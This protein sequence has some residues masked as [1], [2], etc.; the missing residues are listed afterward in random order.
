[1]V[2]NKVK[3]EEACR[4]S[5]LCKTAELP[6]PAPLVTSEK[7]DASAQSSHDT[8]AA[9]LQALQQLISRNNLQGNTD[10]NSA[11]VMI[12]GIPVK[13]PLRT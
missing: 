3:T 9:A 13:I 12:N 10:K 4:R 11:T 6:K 7:T 8:A 5:G 1:M 2:H